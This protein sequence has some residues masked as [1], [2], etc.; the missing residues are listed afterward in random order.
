MI[1]IL[2][3]SL[4][5][6]FSLPALAGK[7]PH[8][9]SGYVFEDEPEKFVEAYRRAE[10]EKKPIQVIFSQLYGCPYCE[11]MKNN[12]LGPSQK[13]KK[14]WNES[15]VTVV[16]DALTNR[17]VPI[18]SKGTVE[19]VRDFRYE[20]LKIFRGT[21]SAVFLCPD[22]SPMLVETQSGR[23]PFGWI[24]G[25]NDEAGFLAVHENVMLLRNSCK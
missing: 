5:W 10:K 14:V 4:V 8:L 1:R 6:F 21:P 9:P 12:V 23:R 22:G 20:H 25:A 2:L 16:M 19:R 3:F 11:W 17:K 13:L 24:G 18:D 15:Y 7:D